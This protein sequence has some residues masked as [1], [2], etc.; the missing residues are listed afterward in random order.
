MLFFTCAGEKSLNNDGGTT[1]AGPEPIL[2]YE[3]GNRL[4]GGVK[5]RVFRFNQATATAKFHLLAEHR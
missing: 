2:L 4:P 5:Y 1:T 3:V